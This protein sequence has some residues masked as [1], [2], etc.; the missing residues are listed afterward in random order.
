MRHPKATVSAAPSDPSMQHLSSRHNPGGNKKKKKKSCASRQISLTHASP[1]T[2]AYLREVLGLRSVRLG[3]R[4]RWRRVCRSVAVSGTVCRSSRCGQP[5]GYNRRGRHTRSL[6]CRGGG[7]GHGRV[8]RRRRAAGRG[9]HPR[10]RNPRKAKGDHGPRVV[11][12]DPGGG[13]G[14]WGHNNRFKITLSRSRRAKR[15]ADIFAGLQSGCLVCASEHDFHKRWVTS[16]E[17]AVAHEATS[18][19]VSKRRQPTT[20]ET[21]RLV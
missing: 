1:T 16:T 19:L 9:I 8:G 11:E 2:P 5:A 6:A 7:C 12:Q 21:C 4:R 18:G 20:K 10:T 15:R 17:D 14:H 13:V 3:L